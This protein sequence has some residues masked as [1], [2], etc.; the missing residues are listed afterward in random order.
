MT[1]QLASLPFQRR[2]HVRI[3][4]VTLGVLVL[5]AGALMLLTRTQQERASLEWTQRMNLGLARYIIEHQPR[6]LLVANGRVDE[7]L[8]RVMALDV[9]MTN[10]A[11]EV[12]LLDAQGRIL[13]HAIEGAAVPARK[14]SCGC[15]PSRLPM[16]L[17]PRKRNA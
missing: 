6:P 4:A 15:S 13:S 14:A 16:A 9:M 11:L 2:L 12:Y 17:M 3:G 1:A 8:L 5:M 7:P 10:P